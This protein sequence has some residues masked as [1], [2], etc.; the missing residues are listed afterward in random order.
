MKIIQ[1]P[2]GENVIQHCAGCEPMRT[3]RENIE[4]IKISFKIK[5]V[6]STFCKK[7]ARVMEQE[8]D[9]FFNGSKDES[10]EPERTP[11]GSL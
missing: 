1:W 6:T 3:H 10:E 7:C 11:K 2:G 8:M 4:A 5:K 9:E